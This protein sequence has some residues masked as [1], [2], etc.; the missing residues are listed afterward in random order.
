[1]NMIG[2]ENTLTITGDSSDSVNLGDGWKEAGTIE[3]DGQKYTRY[4]VDHTQ[5]DI[6]DQL[7][8]LQL[9]IDTNI[10]VNNH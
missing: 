10:N 1:L 3:Q 8:Q 7:Q 2:R 4:E 6:D 5:V 9:L